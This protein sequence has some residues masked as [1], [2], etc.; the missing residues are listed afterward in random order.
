MSAAKIFSLASLI[1]AV[2]AEWMLVNVPVS[3]V[4]GQFPATV[5]ARDE[6]VTFTAPASVTGGSFSFSYAP[7]TEAERVLL[8]AYFDN[9][10]LSDQTLQ[11]FKSL[12][13]SAPSSPGM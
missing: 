12:Q 3:E 13:V 8:D 10:R 4:G 5:R 1:G 7:P 9:A 2:V 6:I 11:A